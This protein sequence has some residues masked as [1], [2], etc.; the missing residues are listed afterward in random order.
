MA[1]GYNLVNIWAREIEYTYFHLDLNRSSDR[2]IEIDI[3]FK[4]SSSSG[5]V[6][7]VKYMLLFDSN[8]TIIDPDY[9]LKTF[10][11][12]VERVFFG[13]DFFN[14]L[15]IFTFTEKYPL[16]TIPPNHFCFTGIVDKYFSNIDCFVFTKYRRVKILGAIEIFDIRNFFSTHILHKTDSVGFAYTSSDCCFLS[17]NNYLDSHYGESHTLTSESFTYKELLF[18]SKYEYKI[19]IPKYDTYSNGTSVVDRG[20]IKNVYGYYL[21]S[22][23]YHYSYFSF[24]NDNDGVEFIY[25]DPV[26]IDGSVVYWDHYSTSFVDRLKSLS[27][28]SYTFICLPS[29]LQDL[30]NDFFLLNANLLFSSTPLKLDT[31]IY[32]EVVSKIELDGFLLP[33]KNHYLEAV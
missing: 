32:F 8:G 31:N 3:S 29:E 11:I 30:V 26:L 7:H 4:T 13:S 33:L 2:S 19:L 17:S 23:G 24:L 5:G 18:E 20:L 22:Y 27:S 9:S 21:D 6:V 16:S 28:L 14:S 10:N 1:C 15:D 12:P 25:N